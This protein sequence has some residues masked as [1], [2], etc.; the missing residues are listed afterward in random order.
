MTADEAVMANGPNEQRILGVLQCGKR[1]ISMSCIVERTVTFGLIEASSGNGGA[2]SK[3][4]RRICEHRQVSF[5]LD[6]P[7]ETS[8]GPGGII[9]GD[10]SWID[11]SQNSVK[12]QVPVPAPEFSIESVNS[13]NRTIWRA[14]LS[15]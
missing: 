1:E 7:F 2:G 9:C 3:Q 12:G 10:I 11:S 5:R 8:S 13:H 15:P 4:K 6:A 14:L